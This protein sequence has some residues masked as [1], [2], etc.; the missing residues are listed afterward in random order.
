[1]IEIGTRQTQGSPG[2]HAKEPSLAQ[3]FAALRTS[4]I[5][6]DPKHDDVVRR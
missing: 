4:G 6:D 3:F 2:F 1:M 5:P